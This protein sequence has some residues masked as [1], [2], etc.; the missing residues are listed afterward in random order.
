MRS[1]IPHLS[2]AEGL[3]LELLVGNDM[4]GL[5][6]VERSGG[7]LKRGTV[8]VT[9]GRMQEKGYVESRA[10]PVPARGIG[11]PRRRYRSTPFGRRMLEASTAAALAFADRLTR[12]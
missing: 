8:Y 5:E 2:H 3:I 11:L 9:L 12:V 6:L 10:E 1:T 4:I 7:K